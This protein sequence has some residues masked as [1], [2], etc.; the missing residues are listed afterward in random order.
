MQSTLTRS[1]LVL[2][3]IA[4]LS[5]CAGMTQRQQNAAIGAAVGG[6]AGSVLTNGSTAGTV[7]GAAIGGIIGNGGVK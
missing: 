6:I 5:G 3:A 4:S 2:L 7:G 1:A